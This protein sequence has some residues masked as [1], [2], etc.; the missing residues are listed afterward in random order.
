MNSLASHK[1]RVGL[2]SV[3]LFVCSV[4]PFAGTVRAQLVQESDASQVPDFLQKVWHE[5]DQLRSAFYFGTS[6]AAYSLA[7]TMTSF[8]LISAGYTPG[9]VEMTNSACSGC[10][11]MGTK[12]FLKFA[13]TWTA[14]GAFVMSSTGFSWLASHLVFDSVEFPPLGRVYCGITSMIRRAPVNITCDASA[15]VVLAK[16][17]ALLNVTEWDFGD[18]KGFQSMGFVV[19]EYPITQAGNYQIKARVNDSLGHSTLVTFDLEVLGGAPDIQLPL[20]PDYPGVDSPSNITVSSGGVT[21]VFE[22]PS[23]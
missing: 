22:C 3:L 15:S 23:N 8:G 17:A 21:K 16:D 10:S 7:A 4:L 12:G 5:E 19:D 1:F 11:L 18:G 6:L 9:S 14:I 13:A 20:K 2:C